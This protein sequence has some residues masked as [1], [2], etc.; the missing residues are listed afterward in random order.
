MPPLPDTV[1]IAVA[2][3]SPWIPWVHDF[4]L[5]QSIGICFLVSCLCSGPWVE[6][7]PLPSEGGI[8][9]FFFSWM[10]SGETVWS[11]F[12]SFNFFFFF[13]KS[14]PTKVNYSLQQWRT[15]S[16]IWGPKH[17]AQH[18]T[19]IM[20]GVGK[21]CN[22]H[23]NHVQWIEIYLLCSN[24]RFCLTGIVKRLAKGQG[25]AQAVSGLFL[26]EC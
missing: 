18:L 23:C 1:L 13:S 10:A 11:P 3:G 6:T 26:H 14:P 16:Y 9:S 20:G 4:A 17:F 22:E 2:A 15:L 7:A 12:T 25:W 8:Q 19:H 24:F 21:W 5:S